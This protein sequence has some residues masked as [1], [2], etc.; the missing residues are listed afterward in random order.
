MIKRSIKT[1]PTRRRYSTRFDLSLLVEPRGADMHGHCAD[2][3]GFRLPAED[4]KRDA[5]DKKG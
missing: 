1:N 2:G 5:V 3:A 4:L